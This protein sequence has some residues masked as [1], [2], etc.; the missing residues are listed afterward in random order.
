MHGAVPPKRRER[1]GRQI[2]RQGKA[3]FIIITALEREFQRPG[4]G[5]RFQALG[6]RD[7]GQHELGPQPAGG[8]DMA[9]IGQQAIGNINAA[10][11]H[12]AERQAGL[13]PGFGPVETRVLGRGG[14]LGPACPQALQRPGRGP[15]LARH[16][17]MIARPGAGAAERLAPRPLALDLHGHGQR[18]PAEIAADQD[19]RVA[20]GQIVKGGGKAAEPVRVIAGQGQRQAE[21]A[22]PRAH[23]RHIAQVHGQRLVGD[24]FSRSVG[25]KMRAGHQ[26]IYRNQQ[27]GV[28]RRADDRR[29][30][31]DAE[32]QIALAFRICALEVARYDLEFIQGA[33]PRAENRV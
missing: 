29:V 10:M 15:Q 23:R 33:A 22:R 27:F 1:R 3:K 11:G 4:P 24:I 20:P 30:I 5:L 6:K 26:R 16:I 28:R 2:G 17:D 25:E 19:Q 18:P 32:P 9:E 14:R 8:K 31:A 7:G 21:P 12:G 13:Y